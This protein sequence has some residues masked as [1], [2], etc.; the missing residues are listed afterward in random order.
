MSRASV[1]LGL[2]AALLLLTAS[3][4]DGRAIHSDTQPTRDGAHPDR[5]STTRCEGAAD[6]VACGMDLRCRAG[7]CV[8]ELCGDGVVDPSEACDDGNEQQGDGCDP[9]CH[10]EPARCGNAKREADEECDDG[11]LLDRDACSNRCLARS[12][13]NARL[14][15]D[16]ECDDGNSEDADACSNGCRL[17]S[18]RNGRLDPGEQCDDGNT[19]DRADGCTNGCRLSVC[20]NGALEKYEDCDDGNMRDG[21]ACPSD[22]QY[23]VCGNGQLEPG[24]LCEGPRLT[25]EQTGYRYRSCGADCRHW[26]AENDDA[27][28]RCQRDMH[29]G[30]RNYK[31]IDVY[32]TCLSNVSQQALDFG[33][34]RYDPDYPNF[35]MKCARV[36]HCALEHDCFSDP[37]TGGTGC[38]CGSADPDTCLIQGP[39]PDAPCAREWE[40][41]ARS[42][43]KEEVAV[44][45][46]DLAFPSAWA[47]F[48][49]EC[50]RHVPIDANDQGCGHV[51][52]AP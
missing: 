29:A 15:L 23:R 41:A 28:L 10:R 19:T 1:L 30:C 51:C 17:V 46:A 31:G 12:C 47:F 35:V 22:C 43:S 20:G 18:C 48:L 32:D 33:V 38:Y 50:L 5:A 42:D 3:C 44:R 21:D 7:R 39:A 9:S 24:E 25:L 13:G 4:D 6:G 49:L 16:E 36:V 45:S 40:A 8:P 27:C 2:R 37:V 34:D 52:S 11:N 14:E 26:L